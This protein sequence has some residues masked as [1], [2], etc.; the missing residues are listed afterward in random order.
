LK[1]FIPEQE[2]WDMVR[3]VEGAGGAIVSATL[4]LR[5]ADAGEDVDFFETVRDLLLECFEQPRGRAVVVWGERGM[6]LSNTA[7]LWLYYGRVEAAQ[8]L[9]IC[10]GLAEKV[11]FGGGGQLRVTC[12]LEYPEQNQVVTIHDV[13][14][15]PRS[16]DCLADTSPIHRFKAVSSTGGEYTFRTA[17]EM[18]EFLRT[19]KGADTYVFDDRTGKWMRWVE[20]DHKEDQLVITIPTPTGR[21]RLVVD[22]ATGRVKEGSG[23]KGEG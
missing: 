9:G 16:V 3:G 19:V 5:V 10:R 6:G 17:Q 18:K 15:P 21:R 14:Y 4:R 12:T 23:E 7:S 20:L 22:L 2:A 13:S 11:G 8:L 1:H